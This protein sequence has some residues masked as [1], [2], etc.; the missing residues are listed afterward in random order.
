MAWATCYSTALPVPT[1]F[2]AAS[3][4]VIEIFTLKENSSTTGCYNEKDQQD[5]FKF[6]Q[7]QRISAEQAVRTTSLSDLHQKVILFFFLI[8]RFPNSDCPLM[9]LDYTTA[10]I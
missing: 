6:M 8:N 1:I 7:T 9:F 5:Q 4:F 10:R 2:L 3:L